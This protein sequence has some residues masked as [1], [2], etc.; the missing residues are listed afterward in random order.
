M[1]PLPS[2]AVA[3]AR[4]KPSWSKA[5]DCP[6]TRCKAGVG[7]TIELKIPKIIIIREDGHAAISEIGSVCWLG[8]RSRMMACAGC[9][10]DKQPIKI[11]FGMARRVRSG[12]TANLRCSRWRSGSKRPMPRVV[13]SDDPYSSST[14]TTRAIHRRCLASTASCS[15][16]TKLT[17][18]WGATAP[19]CWRRPCR[20]S[21]SARKCSS[22][23]TASA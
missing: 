12:L 16:S 17:S 21:Y 5:C 7:R 20:W 9:A 15:M 18:S 11:G 10:Q 4:S 1:R 13:C 14:T 19:T 6:T 8:G 3:P 22:A 2:G 23:S